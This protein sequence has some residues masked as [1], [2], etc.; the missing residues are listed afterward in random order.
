M[1]D[2]PLFIGFVVVAVALVGSFLYQAF[3][4]MK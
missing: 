3:R 2:S 4:S 1:L